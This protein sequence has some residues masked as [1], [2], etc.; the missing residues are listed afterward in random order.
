MAQGDKLKNNEVA[1]K[2]KLLFNEKKYSD[3]YALFSTKL[4][5]EMKEQDFCDFLNRSLFVLYGDIDSLEYVKETQSCHCYLTHFKYGDFQMNLATDKENNIELISF[6]PVSTS[7]FFKITDYL[8]DN[9]KESSFDSLV[10]KLVKDHMQSPQNCGLSIG[11]FNNGKESFYNYGEVKRGSK[12]LATSSTIYEIGSVSKVFCGI[13]LANAILENKVNAE[14]DIRNYLPGEY[15]NLQVGDN[16]IQ[17]IHLVNHTSGLPRL[18]DDIGAQQDYNALNPYKNYNREM[19]FNYLK[20]IQLSKQPGKVCE[21]SNIGMG[22]L[23]IILERVYG[24]PFEELVK[25]KITSSFG[26]NNTSIRLNTDQEKKFATGYNIVGK[27]T[28]HWELEAIAAAGAVRSSPG[29]MLT[30]L[31]ANL[32][33]KNEAL[34]RSHQST[35][36]TGNTI[37][38]AWHIM[39]TKQGNNMIW[40]NGGT[41]GFSAFI[42]F[43]KEK[44]CGVVIL[45][46]S[47]GNVDFIALQ[48]LKHLQQ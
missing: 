34:K 12:T 20:K 18:P 32:E 22:L 17:L 36:N 30:F 23:G 10:D 37:A 7:K 38:M 16:Y 15:P 45:N 8:S 9:K 2:T 27:E 35:F 46:N 1:L 43:V 41:F 44:N 4:K 26:M 24:K 42:G 14:D 11:V 39:K 19:V 47:G 28:P 48:L 3:I 13:L 29:D 40:H 33:E 31:K 21:Y 25:E 6:I 5:N